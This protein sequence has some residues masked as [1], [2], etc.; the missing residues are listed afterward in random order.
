MFSPELVVKEVREF[1][2]TRFGDVSRVEAI[3]T[4]E[5]SRAFSFRLLERDHVIR[6]GHFP[7]DYAKDR[8]AAGFAAPDLPIPPIQEIGEAFDTSYAISP[9]APGHGLDALT[10]AEYRRVLPALL[11]SLD[12][13]R[14][15]D[16]SGSTGYGI[17]RPDGSA[18]HSSWREALLDVENDRESERTHGWRQR[19]ATVPTAV[20]TFREG[21]RLLRGLVEVCP[22]DRHVIHADLMGD[23]VRVLDDRV[24]AI[25]DW[26]NSMYGDFLYDLARLT[27]FAPWFPELHRLDLRA[28]ARAHYASIGLEVPDFGKRLRCYEVHIGRDAQAYTAFTH[29][30]DELKSSGQRT[31]ELA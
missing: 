14:L 16:V 1:L 23:N 30:R 3:G 26:A 25:V 27:F 13:L 9:R 4:G 21:L 11:R 20:A 28:L 29:R 6:F 10:E 5:W 17:W 19:L 18:P 15:A 31:R 2:S 22:E 12:T 7:E 8:V 24:T